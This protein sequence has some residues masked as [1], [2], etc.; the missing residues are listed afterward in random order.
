M[1]RSGRNAGGA[2]FLRGHRCRAEMIAQTWS[3]HCKHKIFD[4]TILGREDR[5]R[6]P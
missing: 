3:E 6:K 2:V 1:M 5:R 4:A